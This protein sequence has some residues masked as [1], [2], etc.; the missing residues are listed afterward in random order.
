MKS[1]GGTLSSM[2]EKRSDERSGRGSG[3]GFA[4]QMP[5]VGL[6]PPSDNPE[7]WPTP[8]EVAAMVASPRRS[9]PDPRQSV[10][11]VDEL[12]DDDLVE[13][14]GG[15][16]V[17]R[18]RVIPLLTWEGSKADRFMAEVTT[19]VI[20]GSD[21]VSR[22]AFI[23]ITPS[24]IG[25]SGPFDERQIAQIGKHLA[26]RFK[27]A[28]TTSLVT[29]TEAAIDYSDAPL[30]PYGRVDYAAI[31]R[32]IAEQHQRAQPVAA[33]LTRPT[34]EVTPELLDLV[35]KL[36]AQGGITNVISTL[37]YSQSWAY[38]LLEKARSRRRR[39]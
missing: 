34:R 5:P 26:Q 39:P 33:R 24:L 15:Y 3:S 25:G 17:R 1:V 37:G 8:E 2:D 23:L 10:E 30:T 18:G 19:K 4:D 13:V 6:I 21:G 12:H 7:D 38:K 16:L 9:G 11:D 29:E 27:D 36:H 14:E 28:V 32:T 31:D 22:A 20:I 35:E